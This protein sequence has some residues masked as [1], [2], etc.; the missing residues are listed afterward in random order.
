MNVASNNLIAPI[1]LI[2]TTPPTPAWLGN[3]VGEALEH[4]TA[5]EDLSNLM[6]THKFQGTDED[7]ALGAS[8][9][10]ARF[11]TQPDPSRIIVTNGTQNALLLTL[12]CAVGRGNIMLAED[13]GYYGV[14]KLAKLLGIE[15]V[16]VKTDSDGPEPDAFQLACDTFRP[17]GLFL[18]PTL[19]NPTTRIMSLERRQA[20]A[21]V[22]RKNG[23]VLIEDDV[24]GMLPQDVPPPLG[25]LA[26][27]VTW[28]ATGPAKCMAPGLRIGYLVAPGKEEVE[29]AFEPVST[30]STWF[31]SPLSAS[32]MK[33]WIQ[34]GIAARL[35]GAIRDEARERQNLANEIF[36]G[37]ARQTHPD[38]LFLW[39]SLPSQWTDAGFV[40]AAQQRNVIIRPGSLFSVD[41]KVDPKATRIVLGAPKTRDELSLALNHIA[42]LLGS[43]R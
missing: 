32:I 42:E 18:T 12:N 11:G 13:V 10:A 6:R 23:V 31:V 3:V 16:P 25:A 7:K 43:V 15:V 9:L 21:E 5:T 38:S 22:A 35:L 37:A 34:S 30:A 27:D 4:I 14:R 20:L 40:E 41:P 28:H 2:R 17:K 29:R 24:Y 8:W 1:S 26:P 36:G 33:Y 19:H 39:L